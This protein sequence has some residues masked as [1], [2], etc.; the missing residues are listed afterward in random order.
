[1]KKIKSLQLALVVAIA[2]SLVVVSC[3]KKSDADSSLTTLELAQTALTVES[4]AAAEALYD[5]VWD[6]V[7]GVSEEVGFDDGVGGVFG[8]KTASTNDGL[9]EM[10]TDSVRGP[11]CLVVTIAPLAPN[12]FPKTVTLNFGTGCIG[13][14]GRT[15]RGKIITVYTG[16]MTVPGSKATTTFDG[17]YVDSN[18][19]EGTHITENTSTSN[20][21]SFNV[22]VIDGKISFPSGNYI[23]WNKNKTWVQTEGNGT[24]NF[25]IDD[26]FSIT[27]TGNGTV[28]FGTDINQWSSTILQPV[29]RRFTCRWAVRGE[30]RITRN[31]RTGILNYGAGNCDNQATMTINGNTYNITLR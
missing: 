26:I 11:R 10:R 31:T 25:A 9:Q 8:R 16:R 2:L 1:M 24:P 15:R 5:D 17:Y 3:Q 13:P 27:G 12:V 14:D 29:I 19:V 21:R 6:N 30:V 28:K 4:D 22:K 7:M 20:N 18:K 23:G